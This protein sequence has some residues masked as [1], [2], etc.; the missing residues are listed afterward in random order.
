MLDDEKFAKAAAKLDLD[1]PELR[2]V[3]PEVRTAFLQRLVFQLNRLSQTHHEVEQALGL[4]SAYQQLV[5]DRVESAVDS[6]LF[7]RY[8]LA[9]LSGVCNGAFAPSDDAVRAALKTAK[10]AISLRQEVING[11]RA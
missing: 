1:V 11:N 9:A 6:E 8:F 2:N 5:E 4:L 3:E 7:D 10:L